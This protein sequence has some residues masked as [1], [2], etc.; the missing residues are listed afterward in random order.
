[1]ESLREER[2]SEFQ[3]DLDKQRIGE[4]RRGERSSLLHLENLNAEERKSESGERG[5]ERRGQR[6][7]KGGEEESRRP[8]GVT[9]IGC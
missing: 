3:R 7:D 8:F 5:E 1:M 2:P 6:E 9:R 4:A